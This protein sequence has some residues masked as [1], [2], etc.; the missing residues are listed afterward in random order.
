M[1]LG[2]DDL[3]GHWIMGQFALSNWYMTFD[4][5]NRRVGFSTLSAGA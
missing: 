1:F 5:K 2:D 3:D 4:Y